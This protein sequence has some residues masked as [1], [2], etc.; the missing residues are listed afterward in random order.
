M[1][2]SFSS[3]SRSFPFFSREKISTITKIYG[4][5]CFRSL[6]ESDINFMEDKC[7]AFYSSIEIYNREGTKRVVN[8]RNKKLQKLKSII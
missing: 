8:I 7:R 2:R 4:G 3:L 5:L 6:P 1:K